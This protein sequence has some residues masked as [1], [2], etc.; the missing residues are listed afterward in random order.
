MYTLLI[1]RPSGWGQASTFLFKR[2]AFRHEHE[3]RLLYFNHGDISS[4][5]Y[6]FPISPN[7]VFNE[8]VFD[9]RMKNEVYEENRKLLVSWGY[10]H[11]IKQSGL[12]KLLDFKIN[13]D[14]PTALS[15]TLPQFLNSYRILEWLQIDKLI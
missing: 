14:T 5:F 4:D 15:P 7:D 1:N 13:V 6:K 11:K 10:Q 12:Y 3:I 8:I 9:P 2:W